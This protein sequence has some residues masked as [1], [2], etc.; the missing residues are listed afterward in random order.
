M[1]QKKAYRYFPLRAV[2]NTRV[3]TIAL[4]AVILIGNCL[5]PSIK[6]KDTIRDTSP[7][8]KFALEITK[9]DEGWAAAI[10]NLKTKEN[11]VGLDIYQNYTEDAHLVW[12][13]DS[14][15]VAYFEPDRRG[16]STTVYFRK[17]SSF[18]EVSLVEV[19]FPDCEEKPSEQDSNDKYLKTIETT[20]RP[21]KWLASGE[22]VLEQHLE[23]AMESGATRDC[24]QTITIAFDS[25]HKVSV[26]SAKRHD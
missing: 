21:V 26:K 4:F 22:L 9:E 18:E 11:A 17:D 8:G 15:R 6:A 19:D 3:R 16:G 23:S 2:H 1:I 10:I 24:G 25:A 13:K 20:T 14:Q 7:D 5:V 12:S